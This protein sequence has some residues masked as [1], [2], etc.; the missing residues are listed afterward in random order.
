LEQFGEVTSTLLRQNEV[1]G[2]ALLMLDYQDC[3]HM[4]IPAGPRRKL[5]T[6]IAKKVGAPIPPP[7]YLPTNFKPYNVLKNLITEEEAQLARDYFS[8]ETPDPIAAGSD[9]KQLVLNKRIVLPALEK[10][11]QSQFPEMMVYATNYFAGDAQK[12]E[13]SAWHTG[14]NLSKLF[15]DEPETLTVWI[16]LQTLTEETGGRLWFYNGE[17]LDSV[18]DLLKVTTKFTHV[19]QY[20]LLHL[21]NAELEAH[22]ITE[23]CAFGDGFVF[24]ETNPHC[25]DKLC[26]IKRDILSVRLIKKGVVIDEPFLKKL[27][28]IP[29]DETVNLIENKAILGRLLLFLNQTKGSYE[30]S[31]ELEL[32]KLKE[33]Q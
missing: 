3:Y 2:A 19:F 24:S 4:H 20:L 31:L 1:D 11:L 26:T 18:I 12:G 17:Y 30:K 16:P 25:V 7:S 29:E 23:D 8:Q 9:Y 33:Q 28:E 15:V 6:A 14:V 5:L 32:E 27:E 10:R 13:Y 22:K 21:L